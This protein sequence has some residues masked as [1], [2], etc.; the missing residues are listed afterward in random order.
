VKRLRLHEA[1]SAEYLEAL[2]WYRARNPEAARRFRQAIGIAMTT[3]REAPEQWPL[4]RAVPERL[5]VRRVIVKDFPY[6]VVFMDLEVETVVI[7][8]AHGKRRP[9][10]G[11]T[12]FRPASTDSS[13]DSSV[14]RP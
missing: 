7:A 4:A 11:A 6:A 1:A 14:C 5:G 13:E 9:G 8:V 3:L 10:T 12:A 2:H